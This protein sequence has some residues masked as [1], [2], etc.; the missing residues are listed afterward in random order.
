MNFRVAN[1]KLRLFVGALSAA[2]LS[3]VA[4]NDAAQPGQAII[5][6][7]PQ[8][9]GVPATTPSTSP[10][11]S[12]E[13]NPQNMSAAPPV[14][15]NFNSPE[16]A[17]PPGPQMVSPAEQLRLQK[18]QED[19][20]NWML[21]TPEEILG[22]TTPE[23]ILETPE[24]RAAAEKLTTMDRYLARQQQSESPAVFT[25]NWQSWNSAPAWD[26]P[27][28]PENSSPPDLECDGRPEKSQGLLDR[29]MNSS[30]DDRASEEQS[31]T[32][33]WD[34]FSAPLVLPAQKP[35]QPATAL[36][37]YL[38]SVAAQSDAAKVSSGNKFLSIPLSDPNLEPQPVVNPNGAS[39]TPLSSGIGRPQGLTP[40]PSLISSPVV[41]PVAQTSLAPPWLSTVPQPFTIPQRK[42]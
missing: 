11:N 32:Y 18:L 23:K 30:R 26:D 27:R 25:N 5:F 28:N 19:R 34:P 42:F 6:S 36:N 1:L 37:N 2:D 33:G 22:V 21:M 35:A 24:Q 38:E 14:I 16:D 9:G 13:Q 8:N 7:A 12:A 31:S 40:L 39:F 29:I 10:D 17:P 3:A 4:Q 15:F 41:Q 20:N